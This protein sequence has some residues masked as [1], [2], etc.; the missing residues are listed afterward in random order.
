MSDFT[1]LDP[2]DVAN[3]IH[4]SAFCILQ[5]TTSFASVDSVVQGRYAQGIRE[6][7]SGLHNQIVQYRTASTGKFNEALQEK[8]VCPDIAKDEQHLAVI[9]AALYAMVISI[10]RKYNYTLFLKNAQVE[11]ANQLIAEH[12]NELKKL[13]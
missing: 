1:D 10:E 13:I 9:L 5:L 4:Y 11:Y 12:S 2:Q 7:L 6:Q 8:F 3:D